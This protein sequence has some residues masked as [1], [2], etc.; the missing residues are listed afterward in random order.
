MSRWTSVCAGD[1][2]VDADVGALRRR[3]HARPGRARSGDE[4]HRWFIDEHDL[5]FEVRV[6]TVAVDDDVVLAGI[7]DQLRSMGAPQARAVDEHLGVRHRRL[8]LEA[9]V[10]PVGRRRLHLELRD[11]VL[12]SGDVHRL[13]QRLELGFASLDEVIAGDE[14]RH[15]DGRAP[16]V[17]AVD[18]DLGVGL[19]RD[20]AQAAVARA[21]G[22]ERRRDAVSLLG[23]TSVMFWRQGFYSPIAGTSTRRGRPP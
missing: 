23:Q 19:A 6:E 5:N 7:E 22:P 10:R 20:D 15:R 13:L 8:H 18:E 14:A 9:R 11:G 2:A 21:R 4:L 17:I 12:A 3:Q 16:L 1:L